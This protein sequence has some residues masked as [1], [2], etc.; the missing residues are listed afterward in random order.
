M[1]LEVRGLYHYP[2]KGLSA[3]ALDHVRLAIGESFPF[4]RVYGLARFDSGYDPADYR[5]MPKTR[6][7]VLVR[8]ER[9]AELSTVFDTHTKILDVRIQGRQ[10]LSEDLETEAGRAAV[11]RFFADMFDL[12]DGREPSIAIGGENRFTDISVHSIQLMNAVSLINLATVRDFEARAGTPLD[13]LRFRANLYFD[14]LPAY[15]EMDMIGQEIVVGAARLR[16]LRRTRRCAATEVNPTTA[17]RDV[18]V[19]RLLMEQLGHVDM[20]V[21]AEVIQAGAIAIGSRI[22]LS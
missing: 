5:P 22:S 9:L 12:R 2:V 7:I 4:D 3:Q 11:V 21:Y 1:S 18:P 6:F 16:I 13:P 8:E 14:G 19:P 10:V 15:R 17:R 20:G